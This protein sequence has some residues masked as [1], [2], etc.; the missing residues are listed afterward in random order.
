MKVKEENSSEKYPF[1]CNIYR[2]AEKDMFINIFFMNINLHYL[3][4]FSNKKI[5]QI[6]TKY[7][8]N[9]LSFVL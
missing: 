8:C 9:Y 2:I 1:L 6:L 3:T 7:G 4:K 5:Y